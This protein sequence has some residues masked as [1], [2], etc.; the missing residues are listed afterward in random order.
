M[1][2]RP[3]WFERLRR[4]LDRL[5]AGAER[6]RLRA[7]ELEGPRVIRRGADGSRRSLVNFASNDYLGLAADPAL[8]E[9]AAAAAREHGTGAMASRLVTGSLELHHRFERRLAEFKHA[10]AALLLPTG[11]MANLAA[12][13][14]LARAGDLVC[15]DRRAH[16][17]LI[18]AA[19]LSGAEIRTWPHGRP[20]K[21]ARWLE[22]HRQACPGAERLVV[23]DAV[24]SMDGDVADLPELAAVCRAH[25][26]MLVVDEAHAT[27]VLGASGAGLAEA[28]GVSAEV[29]VSIATGG[30][31]LGGLGGMISGPEVV[32]ESLLNRARPFIYTTAVPPP[33]VAA[34]SA[35]LE[36]VRAEAGP[37]RRLAALSR[38]VRAH[39]FEAGWI[40]REVAAGEPPTPIIPIVLG[41]SEA[42]LALAGRLEAA[43]VLAPAIRPPTVPPGTARI[44]ISLRADHTPAHVR[45]LL[46]ALGRREAP[47]RG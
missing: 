22:R 35:A 42:A 44:R 13:T 21:L 14:G 18:D 25:D 7:G 26:A 30:K 2:A 32:I 46:E 43:G 29:A 45:R 6:R 17:S 8:A 1:S 19:R 27:G 20:A 41:S 5:E 15:L 9:A 34:L 3:A 33:Q 38:R 4:D 24:F 40:G 16:A 39:L 11:Y 23:T 37:R 47:G 12:I 28:Q 31:A 10:E 36:R